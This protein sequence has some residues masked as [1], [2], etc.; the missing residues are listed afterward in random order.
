MLRSLARP[1]TPALQALFVTFLWSTSW[2]LIKIGLS[3]QLAPLTFAGLRYTV[4]A[5]VL[6]A[7]L[8]RS[9]ARRAELASTTPAT[10]WKLA[11]LGVV[12][13]ALTQGA[14]FVGLDLLPAAT[15]SLLLSFTPALVTVVAVKVTGESAQTRQWLGMAVAAGGAA[16]YLG[17]ALGV[18]SVAGLVVGVVALTSNAGASL[19]GRLVNRDANLSPLVV[20]TPTMALGGLLTLFAG[21]AIDGVPRLSLDAWA[22]VVW[23]AIVNTAFAFT[24][25][26]HTLRS[27]T[28]TESSAIN[29][30]MLVQIA[31]LAWW[32]LGEDL[33]G[34]QWMA[35]AIVSLGIWLVRRRP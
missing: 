26:N 23:L 16:I 22:I 25:W 30:T 4:A 15:L 8:V 11:A 9:P 33:S 24:L 1:S 7:W 21:V 6:G 17:P 3:E 14:Q 20:T 27:L 10:R 31:V 32:V 19:L 34:L 35:L 5:A 18:T 28:A 2:V 12:M 29:N 13:Y